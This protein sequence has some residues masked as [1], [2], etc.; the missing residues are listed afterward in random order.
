[1]HNGAANDDALG[2]VSA[3]SLSPFKARVLL[4]LALA[5]GIVARDALQRAFDT[6]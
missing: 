6:L 4:M 5:N 1:M 2:F 3:G